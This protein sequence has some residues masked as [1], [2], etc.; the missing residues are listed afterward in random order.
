MASLLI[1]NPEKQDAV[2]TSVLDDKPN[3]PYGCRIYL[4][5]DELKKLGFTGTPEIGKKLNISG[6]AEVVS[7]N[8]EKEVGDVKEFAISLQFIDME[9]GS[10]EAKKS[11]ADT[12]YNKG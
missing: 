6:V 5:P 3:Y 2:K 1:S 11:A 4:G 7:V 9:L 12:I 8:V 10:S